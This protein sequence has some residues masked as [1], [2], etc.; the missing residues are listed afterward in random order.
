MATCH[1]LCLMESNSLL[2][3]LQEHTLLA[4]SSL[5][6]KL[7]FL[8][9]LALFRGLYGFGLLIPTHL[10]DECTQT[11]E[12]QIQRNADCD[13]DRQSV[14]HEANEE[15]HEVL[16]E[17]DQVLNGITRHTFGFPAGDLQRLDGLFS[18]H[19]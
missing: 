16:I 7:L 15:I 11:N 1:P 12:D 18:D 13:Q 5:I 14:K 2:L 17:V 19:M 8:F 4:L 9:L 10:A 3:G 6:L